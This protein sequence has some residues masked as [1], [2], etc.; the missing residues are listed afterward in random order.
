MVVHKVSCQNTGKYNGGFENQF[1]AGMVVEKSLTGNVSVFFYPHATAENVIYFPHSHN[2]HFT[3]SGIFSPD[4][5]KVSMIL[6]RWCDSW[7][8]K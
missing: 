5:F 7:A 2:P 1:V 8:I 6:P 3:A 4:C